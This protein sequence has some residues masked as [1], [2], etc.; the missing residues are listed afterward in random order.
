[1]L[2]ELVVY[3]PEARQ[4]VSLN[5]S[6]RAIWELC[7]GSRTVDDICGKLNELTR[8]PLDLLRADVQAAIDRLESL[9]LL[10]VHRG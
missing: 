1:V 10:A 9:G 3:C 6:A 5:P 7:D 4:A 2:D 8:A